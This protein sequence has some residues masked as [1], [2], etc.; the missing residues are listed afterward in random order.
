MFLE[1]SWR[2]L[3]SSQAQILLMEPIPNIIVFYLFFFRQLTGH[4]FTNVK[5]TLNTTRGQGNW[6]T[7]GKDNASG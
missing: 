2:N 3:Q 5:T 1:E 7:Q 4:Y 6:R